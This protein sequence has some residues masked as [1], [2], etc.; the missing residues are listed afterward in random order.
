MTAEDTE[1]HPVIEVLA[2]KML[3]STTSRAQQDKPQAEDS[4]RMPVACRAASATC[5]MASFTS[6][7]ARYGE[8]DS[9]QRASRCKIS[10]S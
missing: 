2:L 3:A 5:N 7:S 6:D 10:S 8:L 9:E 1:V 4:A